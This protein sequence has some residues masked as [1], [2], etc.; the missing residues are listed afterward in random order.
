MGLTYAGKLALSAILPSSVTAVASASASLSATLPVVAADLAGAVT[1]D[2]QI[3]VTPPNLSAEVSAVAAIQAG[4]AAAV[5][6]GAPPFVDFQVSSLAALI[7]ELTPIV[8]SLSASLALTLPIASLFLES[9]AAVWS[10]SGTGAQFG[11]LAAPIA[12]GIG[13]GSSPKA[14]LDGFVFASTG[15][16]T[17]AGLQSFF[18]SLPGSQPSGTL[19]PLGALG[20]G[21]LFGLLSGAL[22]GAN[23]RLELELGSLRA[24]L[25]GALA[26]QASLTIT[27]PSLAVNIALA[28][29]LAASLAATP[30]SAYIS[31]TDAI[32]AAASLVANLTALDAQITGDVSALANVTTTLATAGVLAF[33]YSGTAVDFPGAVASA[34][35]AGWPDGTGPSAATNAV[36]ILASGGGTASALAS[37]FGGI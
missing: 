11:D 37:L 13:D 26:A 6:L 18:P 17:W 10:F 35:G 23:L 4:L 8:P 31:A 22:G 19:V 30:P 12:S 33:R 21:V 28:A 5:T 1:L 20:L 9:G 14:E 25:E 3:T 32:A 15:G 36:V 29:Q 24:R 16:G 27:P 34:V 2:A 7:T